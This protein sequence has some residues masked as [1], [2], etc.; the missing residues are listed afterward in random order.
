MAIKT[1]GLAALLT[2][3]YKRLYVET[4][5][6]RPLE[7]PLWCNVEDMDMQD[8]KDLQIT[9][10]ST[11]PAKDEGTA[12]ATDEPLLGGNK[13]YHAYPYGMAIEFTWEMWVNS[14]F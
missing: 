7:Y 4:G 10:L 9:G 2:L 11:M 6:E 5:K 12:F 14:Q 13:T 1:G 8:E 3:D